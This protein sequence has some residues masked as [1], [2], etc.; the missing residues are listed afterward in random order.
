MRNLFIGK[1]K[2]WLEEQLGAAQEEL[3]SGSTLQA[4]GAGDAN[5][6]FVV[7]GNPEE[8]IRNLLYSLFLI[9]PVAYPA[10]DCLP[11]TRTQVVFQD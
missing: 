5:S 1:S 8:R 6:A 11:V 7:H 4:G 10:A 3:A 2:S 9:D